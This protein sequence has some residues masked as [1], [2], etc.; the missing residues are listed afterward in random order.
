[1]PRIAWACLLLLA[2]IGCNQDFLRPPSQMFKDDSKRD[3]EL[4]TV[5]G[6]TS[7]YGAESVRIFGIGVVQNLDGTG[8]KAPPGDFRRAAIHQLQQIGVEHPERVLASPNVCVVI[9]SAMLPPGARKGDPLDL[10]VECLEK[11]GT[12]SLRNGELLTCALNEYGDV[13]Q[14][15]GKGD[16]GQKL[17]PGKKLAVASGPIVVGVAGKEGNERQR[18]GRIW[19]GGKVTRDRDFGIILDQDHRDGRLAKAMAQKINERFHSSGR[20]MV[21]QGMAEAKNNTLI[22]LRVPGE[23]RLNWPRYLRVVR[24]LPLRDSES[25]KRQQH[26]R[27]SEELLNPATTVVAALRLEALGSEA[28]EELKRGLQSEHPLVRFCSAE[29]LAYLGDP[30]AAEP[31]HQLIEEDPKFRAYGLTALASL[32][33]QVAIVHLRQLLR[34]PSTETRYGAFRALLTIRAQDEAVQGTTYPGGFHIH[35]VAEESAPLVHLNTVNRS[36]VVLFG[37]EPVLLAPFTISVGSKFILKSNE[38]E[39]KCLITCFTPGAETKRVEVSL[40]LEEILGKVAELGGG[41]GDAVELLQ[42]AQQQ[43][44]I[45]CPLALD[46]LPQAPTVYDLALDGVRTGRD[47]Q[48]AA[49]DGDEKDTQTSVD[50]GMT[51]N[52]FAKPKG[53][54]SSSIRPASGKSDE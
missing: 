11:D 44:R 23:Y 41:Y 10:D 19:G 30:A 34:S 7:I 4:R 54:G 52:L 25:N 18:R 31:L 9:V 43:R 24:Q 51:P 27:W 1:M 42:A 20:G 5:G 26:Q 2:L 33:E 35:R 8:G 47:A 46:A 40:R 48:T 38:G 53:T 37:Q 49:K 39:G 28:Q 3:E 17:L 6:P 45:S 13:N 36:E 29:S 22:V 14:I 15:T 21:A 32:Q 16:L 50:L 12:T